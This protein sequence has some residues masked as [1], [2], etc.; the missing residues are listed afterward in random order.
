M[1]IGKVQTGL[2]TKSL[3][4]ARCECCACCRGEGADI[5]EHVAACGDENGL[6][7]RHAIRREMGRDDV[8]QAFLL[9]SL[10]S[11][12]AVGKAV[13]VADACLVQPET[14]IGS[15][16]S[17]RSE[18]ELQLMVVAQHRFRIFLPGQGGGE[19]VRGWGVL[20]KACRMHAMAGGMPHAMQWMLY[21]PACLVE[22]LERVDELRSRL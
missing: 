17:M 9:V 21:V 6:L 10:A 20:L 1:H 11:V 15:P 18:K 4:R 8:A 19:G 5:G 12:L 2:Q 7:N 13:D 3:P 16:W 14:G 22:V